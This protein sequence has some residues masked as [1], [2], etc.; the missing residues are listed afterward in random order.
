MKKVLLYKPETEGIGVNLYANEACINWF[1]CKKPGD[2]EANGKC[3]KRPKSHN[4]LCL[5]KVCK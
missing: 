3:P 5:D 2:D 1:L 4:F